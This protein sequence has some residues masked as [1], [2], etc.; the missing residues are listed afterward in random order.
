MNGYSEGVAP[1]PNHGSKPSKDPYINALSGFQ[2]AL[3]TMINN[4]Q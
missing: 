4:I 3:S 1:C 2:Q